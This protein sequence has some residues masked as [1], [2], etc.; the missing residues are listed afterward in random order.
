LVHHVLMVLVGGEFHRRRR[1][2]RRRALSVHDR[3]RRTGKRSRSAQ[4]KKYSS[5]VLC[6]QA[7]LP[8]CYFCR[9]HCRA[10]ACPGLTLFAALLKRPGS[11][12]LEDGPGPTDSFTEA[13]D[14]YA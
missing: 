8:R 6:W 13:Y 10:G 9:A 5:R 14:I 3:S 1:S 2:A 12:A 4:Q 11:P 7:F